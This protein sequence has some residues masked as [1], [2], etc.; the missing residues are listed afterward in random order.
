[1]RSIYLVAAVVSL[2]SLG[3]H[4]DKKKQPAPGKGFWKV[5]VKP[6]AKWVLRDTI[7]EEAVKEGK[8]NITIGGE[9]RGKR[10]DKITIETYDV[11]KVGTADVARLRWTLN[12][13]GDPLA[14]TQARDI[15][16]VAVTKDGLYLLTDDMDD[17]KVA[18]RLKGKPSRSDPPKAYKGTKQNFGRFL[19]IDGG[20][21]CMGEGPMPGAGDCDTTC[22]GRV[23]LTVDGITRLDGNWAP[24]ESI[25][26]AY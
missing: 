14:G 18:E 20:E 19:A 3:A 22:E 12:D 21:V 5:L 17:A 9:D 16:Q 4:A 23:C 10:I 11:R 1:M 2:V 6:G 25:F 26:E 7:A 15:T 8:P 13:K 24:N